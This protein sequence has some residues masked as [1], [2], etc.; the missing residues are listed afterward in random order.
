MIMGKIFVFIAKQSAKQWIIDLK[1]TI[2]LLCSKPFNYLYVYTFLYQSFTNVFC[3]LINFFSSSNLQDLSKGI[4]MIAGLLDDD[5]DG[6]NLL[7]ATRGLAS[8]FSNLLKAA[9]E[10]GGAD[11]EVRIIYT[12]LFLILVE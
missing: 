2:G 11:S 9:Q 1:C 7:D 10:G 5:D 3:D 4:K 6:K 8:A 12:H